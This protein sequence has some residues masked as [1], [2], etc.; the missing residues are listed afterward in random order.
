MA[1]RDPPRELPNR[2]KTTFA[3]EVQRYVMTTAGLSEQTA[4][5]DV[6]GTIAAERPDFLTLVYQGDDRRFKI[7]SVQ[8]GRVSGPASQGASGTR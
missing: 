2:W 3:P 7:F 5:A 8:G 4:M 6:V 1:P